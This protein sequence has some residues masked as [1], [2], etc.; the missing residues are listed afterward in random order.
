L[1]HQEPVEA[2]EPLVVGTI[3]RGQTFSP[4]GT[5]TVVMNSNRPIPQAAIMEFRRFRVPLGAFL[6]SRPVE[7][8]S[9][10]SGCLMVEVLHWLIADSITL[11]HYSCYYGY[12]YAAG[13]IDHDDARTPR[14]CTSNLHAQVA[15]YFRGRIVCPLLFCVAG[16]KNAEY[17]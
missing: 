4:A 11:L 15:R 2:R 17:E 16:P 10:P 7:G 8:L 6:P 1:G 14:S 9:G 13:R 5:R 3:R 12:G